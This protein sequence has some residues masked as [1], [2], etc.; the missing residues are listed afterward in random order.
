MR[1]S[2]LL[3]TLCLTAAC[4][5]GPVV[6][7]RTPPGPS[8]SW[9]L[10]YVGAGGIWVAKGDGTGARLL[11]KDGEAPAWS[12]D[13]RRLAFARG[14]NVWLANADGHGQRQVTKWRPA[15]DQE[16]PCGG[17]AIDIAWHPAGDRL[18]FSRPVRFTLRGEGDREGVVFRG[19]TIY[20]MPL[21]PHP[22]LFMA[23]EGITASPLWRSPGPDRWWNAREDTATY[24]FPD[25]S[26]PAWAPD[27]KRLAFSRNGDLWLATVVRERE[28]QTGGLEGK[29]IAATARYD[30]ATARTSRENVGVAHTCW[31]PDGRYLVYELERQ[32]GSG[33]AEIWLLDTRRWKRAL[34]EEEGYDPCFSPDGQ[35]IAYQ[36]GLSDSTPELSY[37]L[38]AR[39]LRSRRVVRLAK[40][41]SQPAW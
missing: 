5:A 25:N 29:R 16:R 15:R 40:D 33:T 28:S 36:Q 27:G 10:A 4:C 22:P 41:G 24:R 34:I 14:G 37:C 18:I 23:W 9:R 20:E 17:R 6:A 38:V 8:R 39:S 32:S 26:H 3:L 11:I 2:T 19:S 7:D 35:W 13:H 1:A 12:R 31:S 21:G 30:A